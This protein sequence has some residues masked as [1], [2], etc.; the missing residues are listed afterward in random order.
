MRL[1]FSLLLTLGASTAALAH[2]IVISGGRVIDPE[3]GLDA[4]RNVAIDDDRIVA[5]SE[6]A[7]AGDVV[8]DASGQVVA[9]GFIDLHTHGQNIG[10]YRMQVMQ[11]TAGRF[12]SSPQDSHRG[13]I[14]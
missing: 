6:Y 3:S 1:L 12:R 10:D 2:D 4:I 9:P 8:I 13:E 7:L 11:G 14:S 5:I